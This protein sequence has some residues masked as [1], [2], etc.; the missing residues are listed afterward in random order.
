MIS[1]PS[2]DHLELMHGY[3][4]DP[5]GVVSLFADTRIQILA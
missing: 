5:Y 1:R 2:N 4:G 3:P